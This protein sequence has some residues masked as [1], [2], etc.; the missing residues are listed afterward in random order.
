MEN[1]R[2]SRQFRPHP[3][4]CMSHESGMRPLIRLRLAP[5]LLQA[6]RAWHVRV[7]HNV[8]TALDPCQPEPEP[9]GQLHQITE[10]NAL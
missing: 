5:D 7:H 10:P 9:L 2:H 6:Q 4:V 8:V 1:A 3:G